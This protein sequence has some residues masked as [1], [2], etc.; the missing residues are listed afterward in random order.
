MQVSEFECYYDFC[1]KQFNNK[2]NLKRHINAV[3]LKIQEYKCEVCEK[4]FLSKIAFKEHTYSHQQ[5]KPIEC[6]YLGCTRRFSRS[7]LLCKHKKTHSPS[8]IIIKKSKK[9]DKRKNALALALPLIENER[10]DR[11]LGVKMPIHHLLIS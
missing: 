5:V 1:G 8:D 4:L 2:Y 10:A 6:P 7:S 3:H 11:Q 9:Y